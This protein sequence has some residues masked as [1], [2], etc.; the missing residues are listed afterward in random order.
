MKK[1]GQEVS[2]FVGDDDEEDPEFSLPELDWDE[3]P[4]FSLPDAQVDD[5]E[6]RV[7]IL[8]TLPPIME[9]ISFIRKYLPLASVT[10]CR[11]IYAI[12]HSYKEE[13]QRHIVALQYAGLT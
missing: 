8:Y 4:E 6:E 2:A 13:G 12:Y 9:Q 11:D 10:E 1:Y 7:N 3:D 5:V